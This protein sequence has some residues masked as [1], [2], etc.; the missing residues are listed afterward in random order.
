MNAEGRSCTLIMV[1]GR[2]ISTKDI[3]TK[4]H[5]KS[6]FI[7]LHAMVVEVVVVVVAVVVVVVVVAVVN[8]SMK[9]NVKL[10]GINFLNVLVPNTKFSRIILSSGLL[11]ALS[12]PPQNV[13]NVRLLACNSRS[14]SKTRCLANGLKIHER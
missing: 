7:S 2:K 10:L 13:Q 1:G 12:T 3:T 9:R 14:R 11:V 8:D 4:L 5:T 6:R